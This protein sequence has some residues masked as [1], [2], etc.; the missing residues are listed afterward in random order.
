MA[1]QCCSQD[2]LL[3][4]YLCVMCPV[5]QHISTTQI[6]KHFSQHMVIATTVFS[7]VMPHESVTFKVWNCDLHVWL[8]LSARVR[9]AGSAPALQGFQ[10]AGE[11]ALRH[12]SRQRLA[13][14]LAD[15]ASVPQHPGS[16]LQGGPKHNENPRHSFVTTGGLSRSASPL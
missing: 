16:D 3:A 15:S 8:S 11:D 2:G 1:L 7:F 6:H 14:R 13:Q 4:C 10:G 5:V 9:V 12:V